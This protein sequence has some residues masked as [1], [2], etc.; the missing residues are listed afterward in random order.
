MLAGWVVLRVIFWSPGETRVSPAIRAVPHAPGVTAAAA[1]VSKPV[2]G[3]LR[4]NPN[5]PSPADAVSRLPQPVGSVPL[6][7][8]MMAPGRSTAMPFAGSG[9]PSE[10]EGAT[11]V[12]PTPVSVTVAPAD[13][14]AASAYR[15]R[16]AAMHQLLWME[17]VSDLPPPSV[18]AAARG[19]PDAGAGGSNRT[20]SL[21]PR[22]HS[23]PASVLAAMFPPDAA[24][25]P[26]TGGIDGGSLAASGP[27]HP[28][29]WSGDAWAMWRRGGIGL[30]H[31]AILPAYG[32]SQTG[33]V[34]RYR[35]APDEPHRLDGYM[36]ASAA[37]VTPPFADREMEGAVGLS[38]RPVPA[39]PIR[40]AV[41][42][43]VSRFDN[44]RLPLRPAA[45]AITEMP[46]A[47][48]PLG[49]SGTLY[50]AAGYVGGPAAT[51]FA[52]G[53]VHVDHPLARFGRFSLAAGGGV[54]GGAQQGASRLDV[55]PSMRLGLGPIVPGGRANAAVALD[56]RLRVA[57][58]A[59]PGSGPA[60]TFSL[61]F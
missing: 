30:D 46:P 49:F 7:F 1:L 10:P 33:A 23:L 39:W 15:A 19:A 20:E 13:P 25:P 5:A 53:Q 61:G 6:P 60:V 34:L 47:H 42:G 55:G 21:A 2:P 56:W 44:G 32:A 51:A 40:V 37:L 59:R 9:M 18:L 43:R 16:L 26:P 45:F 27:S 36:R 11:L 57:G 31:G 58:D 17:A 8:A 4:A 35:L 29:R 54:W 12:P 41:E 22:Q 38:A 48:L 28:P 50:A 52:D 14:A 3:R 24:F